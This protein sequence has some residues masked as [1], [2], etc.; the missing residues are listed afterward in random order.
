MTE[1]AWIVV[2]SWLAFFVYPFRMLYRRISMEYYALRYPGCFI[3]QPELIQRLSDLRNGR[4]RCHIVCGGHSAP[5]TITQIEA[6]DFVLGFGYAGLLDVSFDAYFFE[7]ASTKSSWDR[8]VT[9][10]FARFY[11]EVLCKRTKELFFKNY[12]NGRVD[13]ECLAAIFDPVPKIAMDFYAPVNRPYKN[14][15][16]NRIVV[17][18]LLNGNSS[19]L[20]QVGGSV[21][22]MISLAIKAGAK[23]IILHGVDLTGPHFYATSTWDIPQSLLDSGFRGIYP[24]E[25]NYK[26]PHLTKGPTYIFLPMIN[27]YAPGVEIHKAVRTK[28]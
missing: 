27:E 24:I 26:E 7:V 15:F 2:K 11:D 19:S 25:E 17:K 16:L 1:N 8:L 18:S 9:R 22:T 21:M 14:G 20:P 4:S 3:S 12:W 28:Q 10:V 5:S 23:E 13:I 6:D